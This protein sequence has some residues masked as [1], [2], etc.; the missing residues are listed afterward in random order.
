MIS[1]WMMKAEISF[2]V[3]AM[4]GSQCGQ[5]S[6]GALTGKGF[7]I[8]LKALM[9]WNKPCIWRLRTK[10][11]PL[12]NKRKSTLST[13]PQLCGSSDPSRE[14]FL[15]WYSWRPTVSC[16]KHGTL[17]DKQRAYDRLCYNLWLGA[18][19]L[20][21]VE[22]GQGKGRGEGKNKNS[23]PY[24]AL[25]ILLLTFR[26]GISFSDYRERKRAESIILV[27]ISIHKYLVE[28]REF[29][30]PTRKQ[31]YQQTKANWNYGCHK[32]IV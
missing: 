18:K 8:Q 27:E 12:E 16:V 26:P 20:R 3:T 31:I 22:G 7:V 17:P 6:I 4:F 5:S 23:N 10:L 25:S 24:N 30:T 2:I 13:V 21:L 1:Q 11:A 32:K 15:S 9:S 19:L 14:P 29:E 28:W